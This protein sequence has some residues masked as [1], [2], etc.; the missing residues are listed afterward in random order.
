MNN[1]TIVSL[2]TASSL[3]RR[4]EGSVDGLDHFEWQFRNS[5]VRCTVSIHS[6]TRVD[7]DCSFDP[8]LEHSIASI[9]AMH[10]HSCDLTDKRTH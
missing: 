6:L 8:Y 4:I 10:T 9:V 3:R 7:L 5:L 1:N 2:I